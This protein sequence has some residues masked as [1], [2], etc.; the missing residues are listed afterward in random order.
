MPVLSFCVCSSH[1]SVD[2]LPLWKNMCKWICHTESR[3]WVSVCVHCFII[4]LLVV[5]GQDPVHWD[6]YLFLKLIPRTF[7]KC[8]TRLS[9][10]D[11]VIQAQILSSPH[12]SFSVFMFCSWMSVCVQEVCLTPEPEQWSKSTANPLCTPHWSSSRLAYAVAHGVSRGVRGGCS[13]PHQ[14]KMKTRRS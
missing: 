7:I 2:F 14:T 10:Y 13:L 4:L 9:W 5:L 8:N 12:G 6:S 1:V 3:P 11:N